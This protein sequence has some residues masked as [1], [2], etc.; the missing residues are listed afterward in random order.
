MSIVDIAN[1]SELHQFF[2]NDPGFWQDSDLDATEAIGRLLIRARDLESDLSDKEALIEE[3]N[4]KID[5]LKFQ[6]TW[7]AKMIF[8]RKSEASKNSEDAEKPEDDQKDSE[9][10]ATEATETKEDSHDTESA[11]KPNKRGK[12]QGDKGHGRRRRENLPFTEIVHDL[13]QDQKSCPCCGLPLSP[14]SLSED[15]EQIHWEVKIIRHIHRR[16]CYK[17]TCSC[18]ALPGI[19]TA[20]VVDKMIPKGMFTEGFWVNLILEKFLFQRPLYK[21]RQLLAVEGFDVSQ[22]TLTGGLRKIKNLVDPLYEHIIAHS[23]AANRWQMDETRWMVFEEVAGKTGFRWWLWV[24]V[25]NDTVA[26]VI[27]PTRSAK[28]P[29][30]HLGD[31]EGILCVDRYSAYK[32]L[33][34]RILLAYCWA[35]QRRDFVKIYDGCYHSRDWASEWI[36]RIDMLFH[37]NAQR[38]EHLDNPDMLGYHQQKLEKAVADMADTWRS[39]LSNDDLK[40]RPKAVLESMQ[41]HWTGLTI[42]VDHP[43]VPMDN[44]ESERRLRNPVVGRKNY[45]GSGSV[46]SG[47]LSAMLFTILQTCCMNRIDPKKLLLA[48]FQVC[49]RNKGQAPQDVT[50]F[51]PWNLPE[52]LRSRWQLTAAFP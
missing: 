30:E 43:E 31:T 17:P 9:E 27:D 47:A 26:Y 12:K 32:A 5:A 51:S 33:H 46:W 44:N 39:E 10:G 45:Y 36:E 34:D 13:E 49:A 7:M 41:N 25:T 14:T 20:P 52:Q 23:R 2:Q 28:V 21:V 3:L 6:I 18:G 48:Y 11:D 35:H 37:I 4:Q 19:V 29:K 22:G 16:K 38:C 15:S 24:I 50:D 8:G 1:T 40:V 42:F